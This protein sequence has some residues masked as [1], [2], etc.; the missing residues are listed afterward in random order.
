MDDGVIAGIEIIL[1][2]VWT[3]K[4]I[5]C[6]QCSDTAVNQT[7]STFYWK[8]K[9]VLDRSKKTPIKLSDVL[10]KPCGRNINTTMF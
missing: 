10:D 9:T 8:R 3:A 4:K 2:D 7:V 5:G 6:G 1:T